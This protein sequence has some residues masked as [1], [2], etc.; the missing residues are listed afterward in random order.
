MLT[1]A[2]VNI[3]G[4]SLTLHRTSTLMVLDYPRQ[5]LDYVDLTNDGMTLVTRR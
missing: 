2:D 4:S 1:D 5:V 3:D